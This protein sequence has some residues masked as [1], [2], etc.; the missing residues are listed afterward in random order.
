LSL[1]ERRKKVW[2][3]KGEGRVPGGTLEEFLRHLQREGIRPSSKG[4]KG[5]EAGK[6]KG[7]GES[8]QL[9]GY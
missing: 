9:S 3:G 1:R 2:G 6:K 8:L 4:Q 7:E 5:T